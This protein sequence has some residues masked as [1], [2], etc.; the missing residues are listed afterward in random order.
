MEKQRYER[1]SFDE[2]ELVL[3]SSCPALC[4]STLNAQNE[5]F[6]DLVMI[7]K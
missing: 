7:K 4:A 1:P 5:D 2:I 6:D 3:G